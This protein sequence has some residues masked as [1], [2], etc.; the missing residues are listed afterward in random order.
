MTV[1]SVQPT[2]GPEGEQKGVSGQRH[3]PAALPPGNKPATHCT[4][5]WVGIRANVDG[6]AV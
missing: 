6:C 5:A 2:T 1:S 4:G 3:D